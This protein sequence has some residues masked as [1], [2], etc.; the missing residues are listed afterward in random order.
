MSK[1]RREQNQ[2]CVSSINEW[3]SQ[4]VWC[5]TTLQ[6]RRCS[7]ILVRRY[8]PAKFL[9]F[10]IC[11]GIKHEKLRFWPHT[12]YI[13]H[14]LVVAMTRGVNVGQEKKFV[15]GVDISKEY[16]ERVVSDFCKRKMTESSTKVCGLYY[17]DGGLMY[18]TEHPVTS[19][20]S[21][22][23]LART[24]PALLDI[25][26]FQK[27]VVIKRCYNRVD[28]TCPMQK[29][30]LDKIASS[31]KKNCYTYV[32]KTEKI[33]RS[34]VLI[35]LRNKAIGYCP[36]VSNN[37]S[38][39]QDDTINLPFCPKRPVEMPDSEFLPNECGG[40][41][42]GCDVLEREDNRLLKACAKL[43]TEIECEDSPY[44]QWINAS[45]GKKTFGSELETQRQESCD[46]EVIWKNCLGTGVAIAILVGQ[47]VAYRLIR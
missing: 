6:V 8:F 5:H 42:C 37:E 19:S 27:K 35:V 46:Q 7:Q 44:C 26:A 34:N 24:E 41:P 38:C 25:E 11:P 18:H 2:L 9:S 43:T 31:Y 16:F 32:V 22:L 13:T 45:C 23:T 47:F 17:D 40:L 20:Y 29:L 36:A 21:Q 14:D 12:D 33:F 30:T 3:D 4:A 10:E 39:T 15:F 28:E 1:T